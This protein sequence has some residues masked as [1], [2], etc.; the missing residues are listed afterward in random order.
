MGIDIVY[1]LAYIV[2]LGYVYIEASQIMKTAICY[3]KNP[4]DNNVIF[5]D[6]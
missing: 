1:S 5:D 2:D 6:Y 3:G 4:S